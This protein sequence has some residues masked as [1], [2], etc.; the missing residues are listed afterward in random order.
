MYGGI[1]I[2]CPTR[3]RKC[4]SHTSSSREFMLTCNL[5][6]SVYIEL[7][8]VFCGYNCR[9]QEPWEDY[10]FGWKYPSMHFPLTK[11]RINMSTERFWTMPNLVSTH[12]FLIWLKWGTIF[13]MS[14][15]SQLSVWLGGDI[16]G[17]M[18]F[19]HPCRR[20]SMFP[21]FVRCLYWIQSSWSVAH[22]N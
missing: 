3:Q 2:W 16:V 19:L 21:E 22:W 11:V 6:M 17:F 8:D 14:R 4:S 15:T 18:D 12:R 9:A 1:G 7:V 10:P 20:K 5:V 13:S